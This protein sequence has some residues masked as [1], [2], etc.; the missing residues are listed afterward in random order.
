ME[1]FKSIEK[2]MKTKAYSTVGLIS[3]SKLDPKEQQR[4]DLVQWLQGKV[5]ELQQQVETAEAELETL[6]AS[7]K[8]KGKA[9]EA[10]QARVELLELQNERRKWHITQLEI[11]LRLV[12]NSSLKLED[13]EG[14]KDDVEFFVTMNSV[15][16]GTGLIQALTSS[17][18]RRKTTNTTMASTQSSTWRTMSKLIWI[19]TA[20]SRQTMRQ[21][22]W[23]SDW[24]IWRD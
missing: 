11:I 23:P 6:Q 14:V 17:E 8:K 15:R 3:H 22:V 13:V 10:G 16:I 24:V 9:G 2:E 20:Q 18:C 19:M 1:R 7:V 5:E 4:L 12:E 21:M